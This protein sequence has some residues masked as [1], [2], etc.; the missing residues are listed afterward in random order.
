MASGNSRFKKKRASNISL[1]LLI[2]S[3]GRELE[4]EE[5]EEILDAIRGYIN[6]S[7]NTILRQPA[8]AVANNR[9]CWHNVDRIIANN[10]GRRLMGFT[11]IEQEPRVP[12]RNKFARKCFNSHCVWV[13]DDKSKCI[14]TIQEALPLPFLP[15]SLPQLAITVE[16]YDG[17]TDLRKLDL[18]S[19][20]WERE[21]YYYVQV[22]LK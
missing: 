17:D 7:K 6:G 2:G 13:S 10:N 3:A 16:I 20:D 8:E 22:R 1:E 18:P 5:V 21:Q 11:I 4:D 9:Q 12:Q 19:H 15:C 14:E